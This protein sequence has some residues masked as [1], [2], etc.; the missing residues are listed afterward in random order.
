[1][2]KCTLILGG[3][4][5]GKSR[6]AQ[7]LA[8]QHG[9]KVLFVATGQALDEEMA[10]RIAAHRRERPSGWR[11][12]EAPVGVGAAINEAA[13]GEEVVVVDC[14]T[15]LVSNVMAQYGE[16]GEEVDAELVGKKVTQEVAG[17]VQCVQGSPADFVLVSNEVG[18]GLVPANRLAR[19]YRD[20]LGRANQELARQAD[21]VL[22]M[23]AGIPMTVKGG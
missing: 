5:S 2:K 14:I 18:T 12:V 11:T 7:Q 22:L 21:E 8:T 20:V 17:L 1:M 16:E 15:L 4:R 19:V 23:V 10:T 6:F 3:A 13:R 9:G